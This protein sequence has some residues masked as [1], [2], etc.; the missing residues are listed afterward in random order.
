MDTA[1]CIAAAVAA[2]AAAAASGVSPTWN[3]AAF[4]TSIVWTYFGAIRWA[5]TSGLESHGTIQSCCSSKRADFIRTAFCLKYCA[6]RN[7]STKCRFHLQS[8]A[9]RLY[10]YDC[11]CRWDA[12]G[13]LSLFHLLGHS[14]ALLSS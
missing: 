8:R 10:I 5:V 11:L 13:V 3:A 7:E 2:V 14:Q 4:A 6:S 12:S 9:S 1:P